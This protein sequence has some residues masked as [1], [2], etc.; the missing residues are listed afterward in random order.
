M[1]KKIPYLII[2]LGVLVAVYPFASNLYSSYWENRMLDEA[3][4]LLGGENLAV[5]EDLSQTAAYSFTQ[6]NQAFEEE[7]AEDQDNPPSQEEPAESSSQERTA[8][9]DDGPSDS[10]VSYVERGA[11]IGK[12]EIPSIDVNLPLLFG[13]DAQTLDRGAGQMIGTAAPGEIGNTAIAGHRA[14][15]DG[16]FFYR[17]NELDVGDEIIVQTQDGTFVYTVYDTKI[18]D[19]TDLSVLNRNQTDRIVT[20]ITCHPRY[21]ADYRL[22]VHGRIAEDG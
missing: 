19:P 7:E 3:E 12:I 15:R 9:L 6:M 20:L 13:S 11:V 18:V 2:L 16:R 21:T 17:L 1:K 22:I 5:E 8:P 4:A 14:N 10:E